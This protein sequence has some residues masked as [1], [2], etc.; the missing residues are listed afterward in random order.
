MVAAL[1]VEPPHRS[2]RLVSLPRPAAVVVVVAMQRLQRETAAY[3]V[4]AVA[5][6]AAGSHRTQRAAMAATDQSRSSP[7]SDRLSRMHKIILL[8]VLVLFAACTTTE[9]Q[10][11]SQTEQSVVR[12]R[13]AAVPPPPPADAPAPGTAGWVSCFTS[14]N[15]NAACNL[16]VNYC[17]F[18]AQVAGN[19]GSC[20]TSCPHSE[21]HCDGPE[22]CSSGQTCF[23]SLWNDGMNHWM[24]AC[25][26]TAPSSVGINPVLMTEIMCH[27]NA[28]CPAAKPTCTP[29]D[30]AA[31]YDLAANISV[32]R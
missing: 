12:K 2:A 11:T 4:A 18:N 22:D 7:I 17:C 5:V 8:S 14:G 21:E 28:Q 16:A 15:P 29:S 9:D 26:T 25:S 23:G 32:C 27:T 19:D 10:A 24:L 6:V 3:Q 30:T 13:D 20:T 1:S 31:N